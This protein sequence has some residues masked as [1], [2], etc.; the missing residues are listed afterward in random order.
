MWRWIS[1]GLIVVLIGGGVFCGIK[2]AELSNRLDE[3]GI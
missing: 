1:V 3:F 2:I